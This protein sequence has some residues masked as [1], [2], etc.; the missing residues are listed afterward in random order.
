MRR[1]RELG[2]ICSVL[3]IFAAAAGI[4]AFQSPG[5]E[6]QRKKAQY[7]I[8]DYNAP[9]PSDPKERAKRRKKGEKY[10]GEFGPIDPSRQ[11]VFEDEVIH[12]DY[13][14]P[15]L[16]VS[17]SAAVIVGTVTKAQ[18]HLTAD[19]SYAYSEFDVL[20]DEVVKDD[21][22]SPISAGQT[23]P[24]ERPGGRVL[25]APGNIHEFRTTL[26]PL[27]VGCRYA[28]FLTRRGD[29]YN[30]F[31]AYKLE[32]GKVFPVDDYFK[33]LEG[34]SEED[35]MRD[36]RQA[37]S[38]DKKTGRSAINTSIPASVYCYTVG[39]NIIRTKKI[40]PDPATMSPESAGEAEPSQATASD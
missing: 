17:R 8:V 15:A 10:K 39:Y 22:Q 36:L 32:A 40:I 1:W 5:R 31:T 30:V 35:F 4:T 23:I 29:D 13:G 18:A 16:P 7:P 37:A 3:L 2:L 26:N 27:E 38:P 21:A 12:F 24:V 20:V 19:K 9:E 33:P 25:V 11:N 14:T 6:P 34:T 28:L